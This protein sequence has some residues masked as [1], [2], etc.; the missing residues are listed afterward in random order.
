MNQYKEQWLHMCNLIP[1]Q[2]YS[3][4]RDEVDQY[5][6]TLDKGYKLAKAQNRTANAAITFVIIS[7]MDGPIPVMDVVALGVATTMA[8][9]AWHDYFTS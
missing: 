4:I 7:S 6:H 2:L 1:Q 5:A 8:A 3:D 9:I